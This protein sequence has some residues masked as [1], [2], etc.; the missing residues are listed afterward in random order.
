MQLA[1]SQHAGVVPQPSSA[2]SGG[3][4]YLRDPAGVVVAV[5]KP[6]DEEPQMVNNPRG[7][8]GP[9]DGTP[10][11]VSA[12]A[13]GPPRP[14]SLRRGVHPGEG[15]QR[16]IAAY[17]LDHDHRAGVCVTSPPSEQASAALF[18]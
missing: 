4:Y 6:S 5:F 17:L 14:P 11:G 18:V 12:V 7:Y 1:R 2:G 10:G 8:K 15:W 3:A 13:A 16:E 9:G